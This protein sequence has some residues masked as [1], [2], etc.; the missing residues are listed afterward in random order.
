MAVVG[1]SRAVAHYRVVDVAGQGWFLAAE[2]VEPGSG[3]G[4]SPVYAADYD[5]QRGLARM[6]LPQLEANR[7]PLRPVLPVEAADETQ[8]RALLARAGRRAISSLA[9]AVECVFHDIRESF[10][11]LSAPRSYQLAKTALTAGREGS[12]ESAVL[13]EIVLFGNGLNLAGRGHDVGVR[14]AAGPSRRVDPVVR[15]DLAAM[16]GRWVTGP[17]RYTEVAETL[18]VVVSRFCDETAGPRG[19]QAVADQW[20]QPGGLAR[21]DFS[22][23]YRLLYSLSEHFDAG[24]I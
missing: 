13:I 2:V 1:E 15:G 11:G 21:R 7:G 9:A 17:A 6:P 12:W 18:A 16:I 5:W 4:R 19:W 3:G 10:G 8:L 23:C 20:L 24:L 14:R 22:A